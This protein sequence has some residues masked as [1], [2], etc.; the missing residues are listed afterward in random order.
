MKHFFQQQ[1][2]DQRTQAMA[3]GHVRLSEMKK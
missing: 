2:Q 3:L 1:Q